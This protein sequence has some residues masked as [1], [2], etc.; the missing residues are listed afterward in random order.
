MTTTDHTDAHRAQ[1]VAGLRALAHFLEEH[2]GARLPVEF[3]WNSHIYDPREFARAAAALGDETALAVRNGYAL[4]TRRFGATVTL[5]VQTLV[6]ELLGERLLGKRL[7]PPD[8]T[9]LVRRELDHLV[10]REAQVSTD[11]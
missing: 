7:A 9:E 1:A 4:V 2:P 11:G 6:M 10:T 3:S 8:R 5:G